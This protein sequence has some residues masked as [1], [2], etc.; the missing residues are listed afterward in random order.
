MTETRP[1]PS[2]SPSDNC[3]PT[4]TGCICPRSSGTF[5][6]GMA[7]WCCCHRNLA[8]KRKREINIAISYEGISRWM[9]SLSIIFSRFLRELLHKVAR[10]IE[11]KK[12]RHYNQHTMATSRDY[13]GF[14]RRS[15]TIKQSSRFR[16]FRQRNFYFFN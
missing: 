7:R 15:V 9:E 16:N 8:R 2:R 3:T 12:S 4:G 14:L 11:A 13:E 10:I 5:R 1:R 6:L